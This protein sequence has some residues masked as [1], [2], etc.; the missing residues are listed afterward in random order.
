MKYSDAK[1]SIYISLILRHKPQ[2][3][4]KSIDEFG[5][6][7]VNELLEGMNSTGYTITE[8]D[9]NRIIE[10]DDK[11][12]YSFN[13]SKDKIRANQGHSIKVNLGLQ[14]IDPPNILYHGTCKRVE[15]I[16]LSE[17]IK[18]MARQYVH[19]SKDIETARKVGLRHGEFLIFK[20]NTIQ[21][22]L[23]GYKF[24]LSDNDVYLTNYVPSKYIS[25]VTTK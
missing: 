18:K 6:M 15:N 1:T 3:I 12:R 2:V 10:E 19:L 17:G 20:V 22:F 5:Y 24:Y 13:N 7:K 23:D 8:R 16:I 21:M 25:V 4:N 9:L 11:Q 14:P